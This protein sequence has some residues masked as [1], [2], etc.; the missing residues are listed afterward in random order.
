[1]TKLIFRRLKF[2][3]RMG[4]GALILF[5]TSSY[6]ITIRTVTQNGDSGAG[7]LRQ[8]VASAI[9]GDIITFSVSGT[10]HLTSGT[11][12][13]DKNLSIAGPGARNLNITGGVILQVSAG[14]VTISG[15]K[16]GPGGEGVYMSG[17][18]LTMNDC[19]ISGNTNGGGFFT[20]VGTTL[21]LNGCT[22]TGN[23]K[24]VQGGA[25]IESDGTTTLKN[26]TISGNTSFHSTI[27]GV[28]GGLGGGVS[29]NG[30]VMK[31]INCTVTGNLAENAGGGIHFQGGFNSSFQL[32]N[33]IVANNTAPT[34]PDCYAS[35]AFTSN[36]Y[37]LIGIG[38]G[39]TGFTNNVNHDLV[40]T[41]ASPRNALLGP[42]Q[43]NGGA[44]DTTAIT[45]AFSPAVNAA[46]NATALPR[47]QRGYAR[48]DAADIGAFEYNV[49]QP[50][51]LANISSRSLVQT[52][53]NVVIGGFIITGNVPKKVM[54][55]AIGPSLNL[56][57]KISDPILD[58]YDSASQLIVSNDDWYTASNVQEVVETT[59]APTNL[60][61]SAIVRSL[62]PGSY[63]AIVSGYQGAT[64]VGLVEVYDL[65]RTANSRLANISTR[66][67]VQTGD[68]VLIGGFIVLGQ[69][70]LQVMVRGLGPSL[71]LP[72]HLLDPFLELHDGNGATVATNND[73]R[74]AQQAAIIATGI[75]PTNDAESAILMTLA[76]GNY[77]AILSGVN[78]ST[79]VGVVEAY[80][81]Q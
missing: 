62:A 8:A 54:I 61:E 40:G 35:V 10:I 18:T 3:N 30:G 76:P 4:A 36:G 55:R 13:L 37:N 60:L 7:S 66:A 69:S 64:G 24:N 39:S 75:P 78:G 38:N 5:A 1:M 71:P 43:N 79:G 59:I 56:P 65:D 58:L 68:N 48:P 77:T 2:L 57:G 41:S 34:G 45:T 74:S 52:G 49:S 12:V 67:A 51:V 27:M 44:T 14:T 17:G 63:T 80:G 33:T 47:D 6:G 72:T 32:E 9:A 46:N 73:W 42:L 70:S 29:N 19:E 53:A 20:T 28:P 25:A 22:L 50:T 31:L 23:Q 15:L 16:I 81:L 11:L 26:C 21:N